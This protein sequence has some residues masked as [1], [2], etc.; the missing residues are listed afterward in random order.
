MTK[1]YQKSIADRAFPDW[2]LGFARMSDKELEKLDGFSEFLQTPS[3]EFL[4]HSPSYAETLTENF[5]ADI[6]F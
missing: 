5:K 1:I 2:P 4:T 3:T 6:L